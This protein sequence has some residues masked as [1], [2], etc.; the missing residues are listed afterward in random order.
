MSFRWHV[1][2]ARVANARGSRAADRRSGGSAAVGCT[3]A[4]APDRG[5]LKDERAASGPAGSM[6]GIRLRN[7]S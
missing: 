7:G 4:R 2:A 5:R 6:A 3:A 1:G